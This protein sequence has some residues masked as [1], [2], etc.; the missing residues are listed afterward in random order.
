M[1][2][3][4]KSRSNIGVR[5]LFESTNRFYPFSYMFSAKMVEIR[6]LNHIF[7]VKVSN[8]G[9]CDWVCVCVWGGGGLKSGWPGVQI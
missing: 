3:Q 8:S 9:K 2:A 7:E 6:V 1:N 5:P 4:W